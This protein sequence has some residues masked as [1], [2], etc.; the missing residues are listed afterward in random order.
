MFN[1]IKTLLARAMSGVTNMVERSI[2]KRLDSHPAMQDRNLEDLTQ[3]Y[4]EYLVE[5]IGIDT[6]GI[7]EKVIE[8]VKPDSETI[9]E[10]VVQHF[11]D[12]C[13]ISSDSVFESVCE[14]A[15]EDCSFDSYEV[16]G[17]LVSDA[18]DDLDMDDI[19]EEARTELKSLLITQLAPELDDAAGHY[20]NSPDWQA[21]VSSAIAQR[22]IDM[23]DP[24][25]VGVMNAVVLEAGGQLKAAAMEA[26]AT[27]HKARAQAEGF[28]NAA[29]EA[30]K[31]AEAARVAAEEAAA[32]IQGAD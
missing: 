4:V 31:A 21:R 2:E 29:M 11:I 10:A 17:Q 14:H 30:G 22:L 15:Q 28:T 7:P 32:S 24:N 25:A 6:D 12:E 18:R 9:E 27:G 19:A 13:Y 23:K 20:L 1:P 16:K 8:A 26:I 5:G 3:K